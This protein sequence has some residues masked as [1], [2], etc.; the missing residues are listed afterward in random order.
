[1][2][3]PTR[4]PTPAPKGPPAAPTVAPV[5]APAVDSYSSNNG[6]L[7]V[8]MTANGV[9]SFNTYEAGKASVYALNADVPMSTGKYATVTSDYARLY[10][11]YMTPKALAF[12][13][14]TGAT[15][16][17]GLH[18]YKTMKEA[19]ESEHQLEM[20]YTPGSTLNILDFLQV[21]A[22]LDLKEL[23]LKHL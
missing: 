16:S 3:P 5:A 9:N 6:I 14:K 21:L 10:P 17:N 1:M 12:D 19:V 4:A 22:D 15:C 13:N 7:S 20:E 11:T 8:N 18:L 23:S 2:A